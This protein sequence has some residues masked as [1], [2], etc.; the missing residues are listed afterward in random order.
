[1]AK[2]CLE[3]LGIQGFLADVEFVTW[4]WT[5][6]N[7]IGWI[8]LQVGDEDADEA[9]MLLTRHGDLEA[10]P[11]FGLEE[12]GDQSSPSEPVPESADQGGEGEPDELEPAP[13]ARYEN[14]DRAFR[15]AVL[16][17][18]FSPIQF[19]V[20]YLLLRVL[21]STERLGN[22]ERSKAIIAAVINSVFV[23]SLCLAIFPWLF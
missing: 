21:F 17:V 1:M 12:A 18:L 3:A 13:T 10:S 7:A 20:F 15:G 4:Y 14:A 2:N 22:R 8:K 11:S 6:A 19:Y 5:Y 23:T 9:R 16:G